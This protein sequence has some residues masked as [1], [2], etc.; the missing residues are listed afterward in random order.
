MKCL[1][2][3]YLLP[4]LPPSGLPLLPS[5]L[6]LLSSVGGGRLRVGG[7][8]REGGVKERER[9]KARGRPNRWRAKVASWIGGDGGL[10]KA[11][12]RERVR[13]GKER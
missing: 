10:G 6:P 12:V 3:P 1:T 9:A 4:L 5:D 7:G 13:E 2:E 8:G 11:A